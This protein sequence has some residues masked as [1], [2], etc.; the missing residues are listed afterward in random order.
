VR[1][2]F[3]FSVLAPLP[4]L[5]ACG[6]FVDTDRAGGS[7]SSGG[8]TLACGADLGDC[9]RALEDGCEIDLRSDPSHC[10]ACDHGCQG[11]PCQSG[12]C[13]AFVLLSSQAYASKIAVNEAHIYWTRGGDGVVM[14]AST[15]GGASE[16]VA[17]GQSS[18]T[19]IALGA[20]AVFWG[21]AG[22]GTISRA[23]LAGGAPEVIA[24]GQGQPWSLAVTAST[25]VWSDLETGEVRSIPTTGGPVHL[26]AST[27]GT[28]S[29]AADAEN[30]FWIRLG[31]SD[32][33]RAP[34]L[35]ADPPLMVASGVTSPGE[36]ALSD[37][38]IFIASI[39]GL[40]L[41]PKTGGE[42]KPL[43]TDGAYGLAVDGVHAYFGVYDGR[44]L[45]V[46]LAGG[47]VQVL[48]KSPSMPTDIAINSTSVFW[49]AAAEKGL[50]LKV[51]K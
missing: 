23:P 31:Y 4:F 43:T 38:S 44:L 16:I 36:L 34:L 7:A 10:G 37:D 28:W 48:A 13:Q 41:V 14:R 9:N 15:E 32:A 47:P 42:P 11:G 25:L 27:P 19:D 39:G 45:R 12:L 17:E 49:T 20:D 33:W 3:W 30:A 21:N 24:S 6:G 26:L 40:M 29:V 35:G 50:I 1:K 18:P 8:S 46:P 2:T 51:A 5:A 22:D